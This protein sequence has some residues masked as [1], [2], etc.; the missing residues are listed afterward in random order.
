MRF[1]RSTSPWH[2]FG[3][4]RSVITFCGLS[5]VNAGSS[6]PRAADTAGE[7]RIFVD[8]AQDVGQLQRAA[9]VMGEQDPVILG[10]PNTRT[11]RRPTAWR[12]G[13]NTD[14][15]WQDPARGCPCGTS[16]S[17][18]STNGEEILALEA[19]GPHRGGVILQALWR[20]ALIQRVDVVAPLLERGQP[21]GPRPVRVS[22]SSTCR[23]KL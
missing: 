15:A 11:D 1:R 10:K 23:Q 13:R 17:M 12:R 20:M 6:R 9:E 22:I 19:E 5:L 4:V 16:I 7:A 8:V 2:T 18:P 21:F 3:S 14:Q